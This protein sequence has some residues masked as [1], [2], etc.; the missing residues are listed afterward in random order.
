MTYDAVVVGAGAAGL[1][2]A[3]VARE[4]NPSRSV[5][6]VDGARRIGA[7]ILVSGGSRCNVTNAV[8][9]DRD[10]WG[11]PRTAVRQ[12]LRAFPAAAAVSFFADAG[13][14]LH[15][16]ED[17][18]LFPDSNRSRDVLDALVGRMR[19]GGAV[20]RESCRVTAL[21]R[22]GDGFVVT[23]GGE[24]LRARRVVIAAGGRALPK[25]G[26]DGS[27]YG[28]ATSFGHALV[29]TTPALAPLVLHAPER[30]LAGV[31]AR[32]EL[33]LWLDGGAA[34]R[35]TGPMLWTH[36]GISG[37]V[38]LNISRHW[39][40]ARG[41]GRQPRVTANFVPPMDFAACE[42]WMLAEM[43]RRPRGS[44]MT[45]LGQP[46]PASLAAAV[47]SR[48]GIDGA[49]PV[50]R[51]SR[52]AR[53]TVVHALTAWPLDVLDSRG[54]SYAEATAGGID[55]TELNPLTLESRRCPGLF[56]AGEVL[57]VDGRLGGFNF[58]WAWSSGFVA[59]RALAR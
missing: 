37:P 30:E 28:L 43:E 29:P 10:Y 38:A 39:L 59:G 9:T 47:L 55:L 50:A 46:M 20:L 21:Q 26:S 53:R 17:G 31:T 14:P 4:T 11:G 58:Q 16:E 25:S 1:M 48:I 27:G 54:Y 8:V 2:T 49:T 23:A 24:P 36:F 34:I 6:L 35:L 56:L 5:L 51:L 42:S 52:A 33:T 19:R 22:D 32:A 41:A 7:K 13:V 12:I 18:K 40:Q 3:I 57:D 45:V 44:L 15:E